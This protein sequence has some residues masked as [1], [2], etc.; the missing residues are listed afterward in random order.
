MSD[1]LLDVK[2]LSVKF[3]TLDGMLNAIDGNSFQVMR[4]EVFGIVGESGCG[5]SLTSLSIM[6]LVEKPGIV[7]ADAIL[8]DG[9]DINKMKEK[10]LR[11]IR[12]NKLSMIFQEPLTSLNPLFT[13][14]NQMDEVFCLHQK[15][16]RGKARELSIEM[17]RFVGIPDAESI[18]KRYPAALSGGMRQRVMIAMALSC[19][20]QLLIADEPTTALDVTI[21]KQILQLMQDLRHKLGTSII[22]ITH[23]LSVIA[24][25]ADRVAVMYA[26]EIIEQANVFDLFQ[27]P[28][29]PYTEGLINST[30][31]LGDRRDHLPAIAGTVPSLSRIPAGCRFHPRCPY[32]FEDCKINRPKIFETAPGHMVSCLRYKSEKNKKTGGELSHETEK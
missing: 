29:H 21:Q 17:L 13:I 8:L 2:N 4:G 18:Y 12:G 24:E 10:G 25:M 28:L 11:K 22:L 20:P 16:N 9:Q 5:K 1:V 27:K 15:A 7:H 30:I 32:A 14:G 3:K 19:R 6:G 23:D 26:G 31:K